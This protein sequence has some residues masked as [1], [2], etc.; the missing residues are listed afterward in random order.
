MLTIHWDSISPSAISEIDWF[1]YF[2]NHKQMR[3][4]GFD[5]EELTKSIRSTLQDVGLANVVHQSIVGPFDE[6]RGCRASVIAT[7]S[8]AL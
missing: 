5:L 2:Q 4:K 6:W 7:V 1:K 3:D 8:R